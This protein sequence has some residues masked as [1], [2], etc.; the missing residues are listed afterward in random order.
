MVRRVVFAVPVVLTWRRAER[1]GRLRRRR[2]PAAFS[3]IRTGGGAA[4]RIRGLARAVPTRRWVVLRVDTAT[5]RPPEMVSSTD[6]SR[7]TWHAPAPA[8]WSFTLALG[9]F[10]VTEAI[11]AV[12]GPGTMLVDDA[13]VGEA[14]AAG[15]E[16]AVVATGGPLCGALPSGVLLPPPEPPPPPPSPPDHGPTIAPP[17]GL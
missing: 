12:T 1:R 13:P 6:T 17:G 15:V 9:P 7:A 2:R 4:S 8:Q 14:G 3:G 16:A 11:D 5:M 10:V